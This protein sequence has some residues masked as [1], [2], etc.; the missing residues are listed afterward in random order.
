MNDDNG[1]FLGI[2]VGTQK[3]KATVIDEDGKHIAVVKTPNRVTGILDPNEY[4]RK[5]KKVVAMCLEVIKK[6]KHSPKNIKSLSICATSAAI[7]MVDSQGVPLGNALS[8]F[9]RR[10]FWQAE[11]LREVCHGQMDIFADMIL[12]KV[13][14]LKENS[15]N[16]KDC[17]YVLELLDWL[18]YKL[19]G[20]FTSS[21][22]NMIVKGN[23][24]AELEGWPKHFFEKA[25]LEELPG[26]FPPKI[27]RPAECIGKLK[28]KL[29]EEFDLKTIPVVEGC[30]DSYA[31]L[32]G[33]GV[34][35]YGDSG[36][37]IGTSAAFKALFKEKKS[38]PEFFGPFYDALYQRVYSFDGGISSAGSLL[39]YILNYNLGH[40]P[41]VKKKLVK[42]NE[43]FRLEKK[44]AQISPGAQ[45]LFCL[46]FFEGCRTPY[47]DPKAK[48][49]ILGLTLEHKPEHLFRAAIE[50]IAFAIK[51]SL[52]ILEKKYIVNKIKI[53][54]GCTKNLLLLQIMST[55][56]NKPLYLIGG[57]E[58]S[59]RG[60][61]LIASAYYD[62]S[63]QSAIEKVPSE[64]HIIEPV[65]ENVEKYAELFL[66]YRKIY[67]A[68]KDVFF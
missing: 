39:H 43:L 64:E 45:G 6:K 23:Y 40:D 24:L 53:S 15:R 9:D 49:C 34:C 58:A 11:R 48:G 20:E 51:E 60:A 21:R 1:L 41:A 14:W 8:W 19:T 13:L 16:Y 27:L 67:P 55:V 25:G 17:F 59:L 42:E 29:A 2:D 66:H 10:A 38:V 56:L 57:S 47:K 61:A 35:Q 26:K 62:R 65:Q 32:V 54:G 3:T 44:A 37:I 18:N 7:V 50:G 12:P 46:P 36:L 22:C 4:W 52:D 5:L 63:L 33:M 30:L 68:V 31:A 28:K